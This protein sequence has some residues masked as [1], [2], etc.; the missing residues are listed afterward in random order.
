MVP[1]WPCRSPR[2][3]H[4]PKLPPRLPPGHPQH[5]EPN[6]P[7]QGASPLPAN[8]PPLPPIAVL[9]TYEEICTTPANLNNRIMSRLSS[10]FPDTLRACKA[11]PESNAVHQQM[12]MFFKC[13]LWAPA[14][15]LRRGENVVVSSAGGWTGGEKDCSCSYGV[16]G[17]TGQPRGKPLGVPPTTRRR[18]WRNPTGRCRRALSGGL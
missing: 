10:A 2:L 12:L 11:E 4:L 3:L 1:L 8:A 17:G 14:G 16:K 7:S 18:Q 15:K 6:A 5:L 9:P 13:I